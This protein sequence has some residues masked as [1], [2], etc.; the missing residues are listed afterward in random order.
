MWFSEKTVKYSRDVCDLIS[1]YPNWRYHLTVG[2]HFRSSFEHVWGITRRMLA[3]TV[4][5]NKQHIF[6][7][8]ELGEWGEG[9]EEHFHFHI[10]IGQPG[11]RYDDKTR[12]KKRLEELQCVAS[13][14]GAIPREKPNVMSMELQEVDDRHFLY[15]YATKVEDHPNFPDIAQ[16]FGEEGFKFWLSPGFRIWAEENENRILDNSRS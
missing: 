8:L 10:L 9:I 2:Y 16:F 6:V 1:R 15:R 4:V 13:S 5:K 14:S 3:D 7:K 12:M 11:L